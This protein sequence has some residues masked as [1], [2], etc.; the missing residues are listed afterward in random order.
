MDADRNPKLL[1]PSP[2]PDDRPVDGATEG[3]GISTSV[4]AVVGIV[5]MKPNPEEGPPGAKDGVVAAAAGAGGAGSGAGSGSSATGATAGEADKKENPLRAATGAE[6]GT[7]AAESV[8]EAAAGTGDGAPVRK[9]N[10]DDGAALAGGAAGA[11]A[12]A[13]VDRNEKPLAAGTGFT[14]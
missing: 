3:S 7:G 1:L 6:A 12:G 13:V 10:A 9:L 4:A 8:E 11:G 5:G 14:A 2:S